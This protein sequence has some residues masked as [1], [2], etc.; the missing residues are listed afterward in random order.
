MAISVLLGD[1]KLQVA[2]G[3]KNNPDLIAREQA[4]CCTYYNS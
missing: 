3:T 4:L 2:V 1:R